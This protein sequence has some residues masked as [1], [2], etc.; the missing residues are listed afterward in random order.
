ME[1]R[2]RNG[3]LTALNRRRLITVLVVLTL[4][5]LVWRP[6]RSRFGYHFNFPLPP[7]AKMVNYHHTWGLDSGDNFEFAVAD[8][9]LRDAI[10]K[11]WNLKPAVEPNDAVS[12]AKLTGNPPWWPGLKIDRFPERYGRRDE[13]ITHYWSLWVDREGGRLYAEKGDW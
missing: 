2:E 12:V 8:D 7:T 11:E 6:W 5:L 3:S 10:I 9:A 1:L 4:A 13:A